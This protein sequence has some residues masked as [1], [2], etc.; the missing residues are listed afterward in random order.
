MYLFVDFLSCDGMII[1]FEN[2]NVVLVIKRITFHWL[3]QDKHF[4]ILLKKWTNYKFYYYDN[5]DR[6][7]FMIRLFILELGNNFEGR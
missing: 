5:D 3:Q 7:L 6:S 1:E 4:Y 2:F